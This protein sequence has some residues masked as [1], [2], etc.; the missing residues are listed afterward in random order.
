MRISVFG[1]GYVGT[2]CAACFAHRGHNVIGVDRIDAKV[3]LNSL[4]P[5]GRAI[6]S[7]LTSRAEAEGDGSA[8]RTV[9]TTTRK[10]SATARL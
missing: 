5:F 8:P 7:S 10:A 2:V 1:L 9:A 6:A 4:R 3:D